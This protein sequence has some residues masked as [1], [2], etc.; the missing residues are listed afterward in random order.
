M[1]FTPHL[2]EPVT[3]G[4]ITLLGITMA[5]GGCDSTPAEPAPPTAQ[6]PVYDPNWEATL[7]PSRQH[8]GN[9]H[10]QKR[11]VPALSPASV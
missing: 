10:T 6:A 4:M 1:P 2:L 11:K 9:A 8:Q 7:D 3:R 5:F